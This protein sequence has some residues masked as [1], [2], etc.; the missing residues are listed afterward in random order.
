MEVFSIYAQALQYPYPGQAEA[1]EAQ[2]REAGSQPGMRSFRT[3]IEKIQA[4]SLA[5]QEE[6]FT[7]SLDLSPLAAPYVG[8][9]IWG[10]SYKRGEFMSSLG[11]EMETHKIDLEG[12]LPDHLRPVLFYLAS[13]P[14]PLPDLT[15]VLEPAVAAMLKSLKKN[16]ADNP[17]LD[18]LGAIEQA[19]SQ[20]DKSLPVAEQVSRLEE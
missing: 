1:I 6:L 14:A 8:Y 17:Y 19:C 15:E 18:L 12:E 13:N 5:E 20:V 2:T 10:E 7:R 3:F 16:D 11:Q 9:Q 4:L